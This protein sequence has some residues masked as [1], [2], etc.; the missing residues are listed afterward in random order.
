ML[1]TIYNLLLQSF[2]ASILF[3][4]KYILTWYKEIHGPLGYPMLR[5]HFFNFHIKHSSFWLSAD[6]K[7]EQKI[8]YMFTLSMW[9]LRALWL[10][11]TGNPYWSGR[12]STDDLHVLT[13]SVQLLLKIIKYFCMFFT[14]QVVSMRRSTVLSLPL[15]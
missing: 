12:I 9:I 15:Q 11:V 1:N 4:T 3:L 7:P 8:Q 2:Q 14:K 6:G 5:K 10:L 13:T